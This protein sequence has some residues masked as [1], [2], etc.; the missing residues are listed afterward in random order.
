M[1]AIG[2][3]ELLMSSLQ[4]KETWEQTNR[5]SDESV[6][7][8][9]KSKLKSG[10]EVGLGWSHEEP[11]G[12]LM[13]NYIASYK[14]LPV[15]VYQFQNKLRNELRAKSGMLRGREFLMKDMYS[16][17]LGEKDHEKFYQSSIK[18]YKKI[19]ERLGLGKD[20]F[21][22]LASGGE[23]TKFSH[24]FQTVTEAGEDVIFL[25]RDK[26][27]AIN[28]EVLN[29]ENL[30][31]LGVTIGE[32]EKVKAAEV[33]NIF[34]FGTQKAEDLG[35]FYMNEKEE[36]VPVFMGSYG[37]GISRLMGVLVEKYSDENGII[38]PK[39]VAPF[40]IHLV[41][42]GVDTKVREYAEEVYKGLEQNDV[43][44]LFDDRELRPGTKFSDADLMGIPDRAIISEKTMTEGKIEVTSR[45]TGKTKMIDEADFYKL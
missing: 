40:K 25:S 15:F 21:V 22:T 10:G 36:K 8:W 19:Y 6:N 45:S 41:L 12:E 44:V 38:W 17:T 4:R 3:G 18:A 39:S 26:D 7:I 11:V 16:F 31:S 43:E 34:N 13:K 2:A 20:T 37:I 42:V 35:L 5:W 23:F 30:K 32:L 14:D 9:F 24:E 27:I 1:N 33:G 29:D 28:E